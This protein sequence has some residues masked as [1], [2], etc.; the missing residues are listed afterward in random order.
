M[1]VHLASLLSALLELDLLT[2]H[3]IREFIKELERE[4]LESAG[5]K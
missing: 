5:D 2:R 4:A 1:R 3:E